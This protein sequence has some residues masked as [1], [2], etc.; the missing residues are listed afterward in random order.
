MEHDTAIKYSFQMIYAKKKS[1]YYFTIPQNPHEQ[2]I[3][4]LCEH[5]K[6]CWKL[7]SLGIIIQRLDC[8]AKL[9]YL[10]KYKWSLDDGLHCCCLEGP[11]GGQGSHHSYCFQPNKIYALWVL[12]SVEQIWYQIILDYPPLLSH[13]QVGKTYQRQQQTVLQ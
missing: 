9:F 2:V 12:L 7:K 6:T 5:L 3:I 8:D 4:I 10:S 13:V 1:I 11:A